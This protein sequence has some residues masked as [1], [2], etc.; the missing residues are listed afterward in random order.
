MAWRPWKG[1][2]ISSFTMQDGE[3]GHKGGYCSEN[4]SHWW[5]HNH[6]GKMEAESNMAPIPVGYSLMRENMVFKMC[7]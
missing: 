3:K 5:L 2:R 4:E 6:R 1:Y 7:G